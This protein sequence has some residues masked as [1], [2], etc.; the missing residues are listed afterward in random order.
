MF[1]ADFAFA[2]G[3]FGDGVGGHDGACRIRPAGRAQFGQG[4]NNFVGGQ[5][6]EDDAGGEGEDLGQGAACLFGCRFAD[7]HGAVVAFFARSRVGVAGVDDEGAYAVCIEQVLFAD[8]HGCGAEAVLGKHRADCAAV[9]EQHQGEVVVLR[10][11][12]ARLSD[13]EAD[14][15]DG[16]ELAGGGFSVID[17]HDF[18]LCIVGRGGRGRENRFRGVSDSTASA[19]GLS[20]VFG[21]G[22]R[23]SEKAPVRRNV[24]QTA[25]SDGPGRSVHDGRQDAELEAA[26]FAGVAWVVEAAGNVFHRAVHGRDGVA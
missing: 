21:T 11:F 25:S 6:F 8:A 5:G 16:L 12:D 19:G 15:V 4:G 9:G 24:F 14:A 13:E 2:R 1:F 17:C 23:P 3:G 26:R 22:K 10:F 18:F 7:G 20:T